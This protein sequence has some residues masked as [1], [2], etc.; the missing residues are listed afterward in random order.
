[1]RHVLTTFLIV[2]L[3]A[4]ATVG[5]SDSDV[6]VW[7]H[8]VEARNDNL[9]SM[10]NEIWQPVWQEVARMGHHQAW[11]LF[12]VWNGFDNS[13][14][15]VFAH[16]VEELE[17]LMLD[18]EVVEAAFAAVHPGRD[19]DSVRADSKSL[20]DHVKNE[21][22]QISMTAG[23]PW[24]GDFLM[25]SYMQT[26]PM[27][28]T[29]YLSVEREIWKPL[30]SIRAE[31]GVIEGWAILQKWLPGGTEYPYSH[32]AVN[33]LSS[34]G[35]MANSRVTPEQVAKAHPDGDWQAMIDRTLKSRASVR[36]ELWRQVGH[37]HAE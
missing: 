9:V 29:E 15:H 18:R 2:I 17:N 33:T 19:F 4:S 22:W 20:Y 5:Q 37:A 10:E 14:T 8:Y 28:N 35:A 24:H 7:L 27:G 12:E 23:D 26:P 32:V 11:T 25:V 1:M 21:L 16:A 30:M 34:L 3:S 31:D 13:Y 6:F 36:T